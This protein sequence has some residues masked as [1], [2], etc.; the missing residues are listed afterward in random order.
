MT[1]AT[2]AAVSV[3]PFLYPLY[4]S[5]MLQTDIIL[6]VSS[7]LTGAEAVSMAA[8]TNND[9]CDHQPNKHQSAADS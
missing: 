2:G 6:E 9:E 5:M 1:D 3:V 7:C 4:A 8:L